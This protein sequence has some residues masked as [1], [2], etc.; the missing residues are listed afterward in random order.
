MINVPPLPP[1]TDLAP[2]FNLLALIADPKA[3]KARLTELSSATEEARAAIATARDELARLDEVRSTH[4]QNLDEAA[5]QHRRTIERE[6]TQ[7]AE[8]SA[9]RDRDLAKR[10][11]E[12]RD[13]EDKLKA[14]T[15][16]TAELK[17][18][19]ERRIE[20]IRAVVPTGLMPCAAPLASA[21]KPERN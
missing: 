11:A 20:R 14:E 9:A 18:E 19:L 13:A 12:M 1:P 16:A 8:K 2:F 5:E 15:K 3:V 4:Q 21:A 6:K 17:S 7:H 10:E